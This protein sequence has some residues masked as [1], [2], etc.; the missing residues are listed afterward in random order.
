MLILS[1]AQLKYLESFSLGLLEKVKILHRLWINEQERECVLNI[2]MMS[3]RCSLLCGNKIIPH[4]FKLISPVPKS[5]DFSDL[6][7]WSDFTITIFKEI[8]SEILCSLSNHT[9]T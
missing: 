2:F 6:D 5:Y 1:T 3:G 4:Y 8:E 7:L 9:P